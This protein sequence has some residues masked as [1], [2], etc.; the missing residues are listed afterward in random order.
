M[1][2]LHKKTQIEV[3]KLLNDTGH[4]LTLDDIPAILELDELSHRITGSVGEYAAIH[5]WP[6]KAGKLLLR[7]LSLSKI[8]WYNQCG[9]KWFAD[10][11]ETLICL[12]A[13]LLSVENDESYMW[14]LV[15]PDTAR[16]SIQEWVTGVDAT[17]A[18]L[19][20]SIASII[21]TGEKHE[22]V[23]NKVGDDGPLVALLCKEY[24]SSPDH[25]IHKE[26]ITVIR[27][28]LNDYT[29]RMNEEIR[30]HNASSKGKNKQALL[31]SPSMEASQQFRKKITDLELRWT[32][33]S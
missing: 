18:E 10:D 26:S 6:V 27:A 3:E 15:D 29:R 16:D 4:T 20:S 24:G 23:D 13:F 5:R 11:P 32:D 31:K 28:M 22:S 9:A 7:P 19:E 30:K 14:S 25:W 12:L 8:A 33:G 2:Q 21:D 17:P 1:K